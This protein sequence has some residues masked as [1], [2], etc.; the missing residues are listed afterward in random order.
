M[1]LMLLKEQQITLQTTLLSFQLLN[2]LY[3]DLY[4]LR[5]KCVVN[6]EKERKLIWKIDSFGAMTQFKGGCTYRF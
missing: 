5:F 3:Q 4:V 6:E 1:I 2:A